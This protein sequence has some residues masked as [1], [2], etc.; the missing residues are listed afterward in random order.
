MC[1]YAAPS[2][3]TVSTLQYARTDSGMSVCNLCA[4]RN[5]HD[6]ARRLPPHLLCDGSQQ[7]P[8]E[9][10]P[11]VTAD[12]KQVSFE[13]GRLSENLRA[14][15]R[16]FL[17]DELP[18]Q[19]RWCLSNEASHFTHEPFALDLF[20]RDRWEVHARQVG[21]NVEDSHLRFVPLCHRDRLMERVAGELREVDR[22]Q[23]VFDFR[24]R[25]SGTLCIPRTRLLRVFVP[26]ATVD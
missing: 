12:Y 3:T 1:R 11:A 7:N 23:D 13:D 10:R 24:H 5:H 22:A 19:P 8:L 14:N 20:E 17:N 4:A 16:G 6:G 9:P 15:I 18:R 2:L 26:S 21:E 25:C